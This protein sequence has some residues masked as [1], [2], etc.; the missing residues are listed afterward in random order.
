MGVPHVLMRETTERPEALEA[1]VILLSGTT[2]EGVYAA[3][4]RLLTDR[5]LYQQMAR[6]K[7]PFGDGQASRRIVEY[8]AWYFGF[9]ASKPS[10]FIPRR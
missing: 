7:N 2:Y 5:A 4:E 1:G 3:G 8:L 9:I 10:E 6:A